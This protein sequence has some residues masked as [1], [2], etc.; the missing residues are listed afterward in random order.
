VPIVDWC[1]IL[2]V[3]LPDAE[4][5]R[6]FD[7]NSSVKRRIYRTASVPKNA[8]AQVLLEVALRT[9]HIS[10][11]PKNYYITEAQ[12]QGWLSR[13]ILVEGYANP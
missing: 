10:D 1:R 9:F 7:G 6:I 2:S 5:V 11:N 8:P 12:D 4:I 3:F 13:L